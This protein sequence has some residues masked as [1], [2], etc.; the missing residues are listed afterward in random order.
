MRQ[1]FFF[2]GFWHSGQCFQCF[3]RSSAPHWVS[4]RDTYETLAYVGMLN[5]FQIKN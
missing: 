1:F 3:L 4:V 2:L 5:E